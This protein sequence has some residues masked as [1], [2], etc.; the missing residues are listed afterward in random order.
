MLLDISERVQKGIDVDIIASNG[1]IHV[2]DQVLLPTGSTSSSK[3]SKETTPSK[4]SKEQGRT[5]EW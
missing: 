3:S 2:I 1:V 5:K 4:S